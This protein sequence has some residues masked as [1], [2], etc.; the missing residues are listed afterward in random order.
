MTIDPS[1][2]ESVRFKVIKNLLGWS[3]T[4]PIST[5]D[6]FFLG[7]KLNWE[8]KQRELSKCAG[9]FREIH[10]QEIESKNE[11]EADEFLSAREKA[12]LIS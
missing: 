11:L 1:T 2:A 4:V 3:C 9:Y 8:R 6:D 10:L 12:L 5:P 7:D